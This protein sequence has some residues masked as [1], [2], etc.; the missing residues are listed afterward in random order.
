M[1]LKYNLAG[2]WLLRDR[3]PLPITTLEVIK[4]SP[5]FVT[6]AS[7]KNLERSIFFLSIYFFPCGM[8]EKGKLCTDIHLGLNV[9]LL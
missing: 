6:L 3:S 9:D 7:S 5:E 8:L 4:D 2:A 1:G